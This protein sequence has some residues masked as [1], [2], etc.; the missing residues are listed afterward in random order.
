MFERA[1]DVDHAAGRHVESG[2]VQ[3]LAEVQEV[4]RR[5]VTFR[6]AGKAALHASYG[7]TGQLRFQQ[8][9][10]SVRHRSAATCLPRFF[11]STPSVV[12]RWPRLS[13]FRLIESSATSARHPVQRLRDA[14]GLVQ[15]RRPELLDECR[16]L[17]GE[18]G[19]R[20]WDLRRDDRSSFSKSG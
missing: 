15:L 6:Q 8:S 16:H 18:P 1:R 3:H 10:E 14:R 4:V 17:R 2:G 5:K 7:S 11:S 20:V 13:S 12:R 9:P 19:R